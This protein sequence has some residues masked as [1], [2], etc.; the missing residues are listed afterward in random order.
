MNYTLFISDLHLSSAD[1]QCVM[2]L[3]LGLRKQLPHLDALYILGDF[4]DA[5]MGCDG[6]PWQRDVTAVLHEIAQ[7][8]PVYMMVGNRD[9][10]IDQK[11]LQPFGVVFLPD[12]FAADIYGRRI[13]LSHGDVLCTDDVAY[14]RLRRIVRMRWLQRLFLA[15]PVSWRVAI[16]KRMRRQSKRHTSTAPLSSMDVV[17]A[18][19]LEMMEAHQVR[20]MIH[21]HTHQPGVHQMAG[22]ALRYVLGA[23]PPCGEAQ[24]LTLDRQQQFCMRADLFNEAL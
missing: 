17:E 18:A 6:S 10:L 21:G 11:F 9:F 1:P 20:C 4:F 23:W 12:P 2:R 22:G 8:I 3:R 5:F 19:V 24:V 15:S 13:L 7:K 14:Q 16:A